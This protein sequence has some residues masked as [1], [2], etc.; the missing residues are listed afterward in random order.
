[1]GRGDKTS[2]ELF[3]AGIGEWAVTLWRRLGF[4]SSLQCG[5]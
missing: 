5:N 1:M 2:I 3:L 4:L